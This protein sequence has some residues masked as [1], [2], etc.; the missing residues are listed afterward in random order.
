MKHRPVP[1]PIVPD[2]P[3]R[4]LA[5]AVIAKAHEDAAIKHG[6]EKDCAVNF[7][8]Q[9]SPDYIEMCLFWHRVAQ[10]PVPTPAVA[11]SRIMKAR[12]YY[13]ERADV[14]A[15]AREECRKYGPRHGRKKRLA[16]AS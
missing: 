4:R 14:L 9:A 12:R 15:Q 1:E 5:V 6:K 7:L 16:A 13:A 11:L 8:M 10:M 3:E 2:H